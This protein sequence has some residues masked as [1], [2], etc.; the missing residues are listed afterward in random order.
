M[1]FKCLLVKE[2]INMEPDIL[3]WKL[4]KT[5]Y[6]P[7][8]WVRELDL[9]CMVLAP[10]SVSLPFFFMAILFYQSARSNGTSYYTG[11]LVTFL[12]GLGTIVVLG[13]FF[14]G[15]FKSYVNHQATRDE[16]NTFRL[17]YLGLILGSL[18]VYFM[19]FYGF[20]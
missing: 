4:P 13:S 15:D 1:L 18:V 20:F 8:G 7:K 19:I 16:V 6:Y 10:I 14:R 3:D 2:G 12:G 9:A 17:A 5:Y 11:A